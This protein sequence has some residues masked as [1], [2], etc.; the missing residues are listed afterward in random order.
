MT[1]MAARAGQT[2]RNGA[3]AR[4]RPIISL[5]RQ[6]GARGAAVAKLVAERLGYT[7]WDRELVAAIAAYVKAEPAQIAAL[8]ERL[9][10]PGGGETPGG[11]GRAEYLRGLE[12]VAQQLARRGGAFVVGRGVGFLV[13]VRDCLRVR[14]VAP[15]ERRIDNL[16]AHNQLSRETARATIEYV[17][18]GRREFVRE[19]YGADIEDPATFDVVVSTGVMSLEAAAD[20]ILAAYYARFDLRRWPRS[21]TTMSSTAMP[22]MTRT[23]REPRETRPL[24]NDRR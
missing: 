5:S 15:L 23:G 13:H 3:G 2:G 16:T 14:V 6:H 19:R 21:S 18:G 7:C 4:P 17:D 10:E 8:D 20:V 22:P 11:P 1:D 9:H 12:L 24:A